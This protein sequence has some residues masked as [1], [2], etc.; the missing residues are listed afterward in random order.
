M[1]SFHRVALATF[2]AAGLGS[3]ISLSGCGG[4][5]FAGRAVSGPASIATV[6]PATDPV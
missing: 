2:V 5:T 6:V 1:R 4:V 3:L